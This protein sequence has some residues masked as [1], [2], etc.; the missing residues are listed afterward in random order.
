MR[1]LV[2]ALLATVVF[3]GATEARADAINAGVT[4]GVDGGT[5]Q[6]EVSGTSPGAS[7]AGL[8]RGS[9]NAISAPVFEID[10]PQL[11]FSNGSFCIDVSRTWV[12][13]R[14]TAATANAANEVRWQVLLSQWG[15]CPGV[16][17]PAGM[18]VPPSVIASTFWDQ[19]G[20]DLL[21]HPVPEIRPGYALAGKTAYLE[22]GS[23]TTQT[24]S[25]A[26]PAGALVIGAAGS[27]FVDW[28]D[29]SGMSG[30]YGDAGGPYP[31]GDITHVWVDA[32]AYTVTVY[33]QWTAHWSLGGQQGTLTTLRTVGQLPNFSV[34][35]LESV[36][37]R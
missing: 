19:H 2:A 18:A 15:P 4:E 3:L 25:N 14:V 11:V 30:P 27:F 1:W 33:E 5:L 26:T 23:P 8:S 6:F 28:G 24:F 36:R 32:G 16:Q 20:Q 29:G 31:N 10:A 35:Q 34:R 9:G 13:D 17:L 12:S 21:A 22:A 37:N 7:S